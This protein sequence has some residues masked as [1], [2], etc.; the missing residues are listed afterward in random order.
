MQFTVE[1]IGLPAKSPALLKDWYVNILG[2]T[3][4]F[5][6]GK[7]PPCY[8]VRLDG[9][10]MLE[11]YEC[12]FSMKETSDNAMAGFRHL[13]LEV[14]S[15]EDARAELERKGVKFP[16]PIKPAGG[17]GRVLFFADAENNLLHFVERPAD[18]IFRQ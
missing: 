16:N 10:L 7:T 8:F 17:G 5:E 9:G 14:A 15:I 1:H 2:A 3:L 11:I 13:A 12:D 6:N 4:V 18:S